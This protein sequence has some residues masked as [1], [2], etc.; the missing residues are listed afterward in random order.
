M[1]IEELKINDLI[2]YENNPRK[3]NDAVDK[4]AESIKAFG[5]K[6]PVVI[7]KNNI[8]V[9]GHTRVLAAKKLKMKTVPCIKADD[10]SDE[11][12]KAFRLADN[13]SAELA[14]WDEEKLQAEIAKL[15]DMLSVLE[16]VGFIDDVS[17][18]EDISESD[19]EKDTNALT[20]QLT[21]C[22]EQYQICL[23][24]IDYWSENITHAYGN[25]NKKSNAL[26]EAI[27]AY[28]KSENL[29]EE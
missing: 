8:I 27:Y 4:V 9:C 23:A 21:L 15:D 29:I 18:V 12:I 16:N 19:D 20:L 3:N 11:Q 1:N 10:L 14:T 13:K 24:V 25:K 7:D 6:V 2:P 22:E 26:F 5:F 17:D 28:A